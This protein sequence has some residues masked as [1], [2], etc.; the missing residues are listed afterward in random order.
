M[1]ETLVASL[2]AFAPYSFCPT[3]MLRDDSKLDWQESDAIHAL[4]A[5]RRCQ[6]KFP[7]SPC[8][9]TFI[10]RD[11]NV[12]WAICNDGNNEVTNEKQ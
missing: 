7:L 10:K 12:Y 5:Q 2:I 9:K 4:T 3:T 11:T 1:V 6:E 8:L